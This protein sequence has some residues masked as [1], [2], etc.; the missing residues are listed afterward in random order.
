[1]CVGIRPRLRVRHNS[2]ARRYSY[3][4]ERVDAACARAL[5]LNTRSYTSVAAILT[6]RSEAKALPT[7]DDT[8]VL[9]HANI[10]GPDYYH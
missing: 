10:R 9:V 1:M 3:G 5:C 4:A 7:T 2:I 8:P 6:N